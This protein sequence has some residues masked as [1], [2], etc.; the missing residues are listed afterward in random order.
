MGKP[1][2]IV[3]L[4][5]TVKRV[6]FCLY[7]SHYLFPPLSS[8]VHLKCNPSK[9][10]NTY[11]QIIYIFSTL[12]IFLCKHAQNIQILK[13]LFYTILKLRLLSV[14]EECVKGVHISISLL[15]RAWPLHTHSC[16]WKSLLTFHLIYTIHYYNPSSIHTNF[17]LH[18]FKYYTMFLL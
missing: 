11:A 15:L 18:N 12:R 5:S 6:T 16:W 10:F 17:T 13:L 1:S 9:W 2:N 3:S 7:F 8:L 4:S 14:T